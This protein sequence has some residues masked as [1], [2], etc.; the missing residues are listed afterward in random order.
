V[1]TG[2]RI[3]EVCCPSQI[4]WNLHGDY[5]IKQDTDDFGNLKR[6]QVNP[7]QKYAVATGKGR[8]AEQGMIDRLTEGG[9]CNE[10]AMNATKKLK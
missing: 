4:L 6:K 1:K 3:R 10:M 7:T 8:M 9:T 5:P 2:R